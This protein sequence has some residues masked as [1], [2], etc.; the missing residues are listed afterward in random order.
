LEVNLTKAYG[1]SNS[2]VRTPDQTQIALFWADGAGTETPPGHWNHIAGDVSKAKGLSVLENARLF[3]LLNV[4]LAD[5]GMACWAAKYTYNLWRPITAIREADTDSNPD[6]EADPAWMPLLATP[7]FPE[8]TSGHST[9]SR[10]AATVLAS[11]FGSDTIPFTTGSDALPGVTRN[12][13]SFSQAADE[14]GV[15]RIYGGIHFQTANIAGQACG[16][17]VA[18]QVLRYL[19]TSADALQ[20]ASIARANGQTQLSAKVQPKTLYSVRVSSDLNTWEQIAMAS[21]D[22]G[23]LQFTDPNAPAGALRFYRLQAVQ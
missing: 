22:D 14:A 13:S 12:Y 17:S 9:F 5:A 1:A 21:C 23:V 19:L 3:A 10:S 20:F 2:V 6:T 15:S 18:N 4:A 7:P 16:L 11:F 8:C